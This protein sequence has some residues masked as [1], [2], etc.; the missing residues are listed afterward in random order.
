[1]NILENNAASNV[2]AACSAGRTV[3]KNQ[4]DRTSKIKVRSFKYAMERDFPDY[5]TFGDDTN[6][7]AE[8]LCDSKRFTKECEHLKLVPE[9][10]AQHVIFAGQTA[11]NKVRN[12]GLKATFGS[13]VREF[14]NSLFDVVE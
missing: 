1:M 4:L 5:H 7:L 8:V 13:Q 10:V 2:W 12:V 6:S 14:N 9:I 11:F 3:Y